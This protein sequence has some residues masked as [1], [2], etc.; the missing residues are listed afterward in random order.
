MEFKRDKMHEEL[1]RYQRLESIYKRLDAYEPKD[2][3]ELIQWLYIKEQHMGAV[4]DILKARGI[5]K[6]ETK[7]YDEPLIREVVSDE[8]ENKGLS[9]MAKAIYNYNSPNKKVT[10]KRTLEELEKGIEWLEGN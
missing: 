7:G 1:E 2:S 10:G 4:K 9:V 8:G 6:S 3:E 5:R